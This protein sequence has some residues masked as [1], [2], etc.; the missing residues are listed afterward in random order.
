MPILFVLTSKISAD[1]SETKLAGKR[2]KSYI[3]KYRIVFQKAK[4]PIGG[5]MDQLTLD[6]FRAARQRIA[7]YVI[8]TEIVPLLLPNGQKIQLKPES[9]QV[10][11]SFKVRGA[12]N[13][14]LQLSDEEK[15]AGVIAAS[16]GNH[17][18]GVARAAQKAGISCVIVMPRTAP[19]AKVSATEAFGAEV[20]LSGDNYDEAYE[21]ALNIQKERSLTFIHP[22]DDPQIIAGQG[23]IA[24]EILEQFPSVSQIVV[25]IGGGGLASGVGMAIKMLRPSVKVIGVE[26]VQAA[27]MKKSFLAGQIESLDSAKTI[28][29]GI[30]VRTPGNLTFPLCEKCIDDIVEVSEDE[31]ASTIL[32]L[33]E[34]AKI[35]AEGAG[36]ASIAA[37]YHN[38][39]PSDSK[40]VAVLSGG[41][42]DVTMVSRIIERGLL[43]SGR[44]FKARMTLHDRPGEL[45][46]LSALIAQAG[47]NVVAVYHDRNDLQTSLND[48]VIDIELETKD[49]AQ[50]DAILL[51]LKNEGYHLI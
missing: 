14:I 21:T 42:I 30:A 12:A 25:P 2:K 15:E 31:I 20:I 43:N 28:A 38:K 46:R 10:T 27:S 24:L 11:G 45:A 5:I 3:D 37:I 16:A 19:L 29:D 44:K 18:Q 50:A 40:T 32:Y 35:V 48:T 51:M 8:K 17:A 36:A 49:Q 6:D 41:N 39:I 4:K 7:P 47:A 22:F 9:L 13:K 34:K 26:P 1:V 23:S 33:L